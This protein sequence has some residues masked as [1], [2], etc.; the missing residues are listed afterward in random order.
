MKVNTG[1]TELNVRIDG[2]ESAPPL[3]L[4][5]SLG[6]TTDMWE[7]Q[8]PALGSKFRVIRYDARGH[9]GS[10][11]PAGPVTIDDLGRDA[12]AL[13]DRLGLTRVHVC[14]VSLGGMTAQWLAAHAPDRIDRIVIA[15]SAPQVPPA[16]VWNNRIATVREKG[17]EAVVDNLLARW[18]TDDFRA[19]QPAAAARLREIFLAND[20]QGYAACCAAVR[21]LDLRGEL[22]AIRAPTLVIGGSEDLATPLAGS[23][24]MAATIPGARLVVL[25]AAHLSNWE[26]AGEFT[27]HV[28]SFLTE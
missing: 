14:G 19:A 11:P 13:L 8:L 23:E 15:N 9:G 12:V 24:L 1:E 5:N 21:D 4:V 10:K 20:P 16:E 6:T 25:K 26:C 27:D 22:A 2:P 17:L 28:L 7:P 18:L 3:L